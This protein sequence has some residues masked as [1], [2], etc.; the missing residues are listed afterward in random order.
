MPKPEGSSQ[1]AEAR[2]GN[3]ELQDLHESHKTGCEATGTKESKE[4]DQTQG[5]RKLNV[6]V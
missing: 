5:N 1:K 3:S 6:N 2:V 4:R